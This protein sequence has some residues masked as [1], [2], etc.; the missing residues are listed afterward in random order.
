MIDWSSVPVFGDR[1][2]H[3][4]ATIRPSAYGIIGDGRS[5]VAVVRTPSGVLLPGGGRDDGESAEATVIRETAEECALVIVAGTWRA[6][7]IEH[8]SSTTKRAH[9]EKRSTFCDATV[10]SHSIHAGESDHELVWV[11]PS[12]AM[13]VLTPA[14]HRWAVGEWLVRMMD[15]FRSEHRTQP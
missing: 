3:F 15:R 8:V 12:E 9:F 11:S 10:V 6:A 5:C 13:A 7:A 4:P 14:S 1:V 2:P